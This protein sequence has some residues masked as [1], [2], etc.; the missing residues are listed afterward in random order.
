MLIGLK[1]KKLS[2]K[3][4]TGKILAKEFGFTTIA[5]AEP[6]KQAAMIIF[7]LSEDQVHDQA[8]KEQVDPRWGLSP[9]R[10]LQVMGTEVGRQLCPN[11]WVERAMMRVQKEPKTNWVI[12]DLRFV[13]EA[14]AIK[15]AG[16]I[17]VEVQR[18]GAGTGNNEQH[19][20]E[21]EQ[22]HIKP[23][24]IISNDGTLE[25]LERKV[26]DLMDAM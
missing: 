26:K 6:L 20:S 19:V 9:R 1:G 16:G 17:V 21:Q 24:Y 13:N 12:T 4:T 25:D 10:I 2:G 11:I 8:L 5:F 23:D 14:E 7:D 18:P 22:D 3:D 15:E